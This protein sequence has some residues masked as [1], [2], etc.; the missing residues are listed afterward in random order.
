[1][2]KVFRVGTECF[3]SACW[4][5]HGLADGQPQAEWLVLHLQRDGGREVLVLRRA[6]NKSHWDGDTV[7]LIEQTVDARQT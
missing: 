6:R 7:D 5:G 2:P 1:V 4:R 3:E